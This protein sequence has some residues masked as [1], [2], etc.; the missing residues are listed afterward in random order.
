M[1]PI[2]AAVGA[3]ASESAQLTVEVMR[4]PAWPPYAD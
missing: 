3:L 2:W 4:E 1:L